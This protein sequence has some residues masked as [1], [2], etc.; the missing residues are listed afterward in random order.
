MCRAWSL[1]V[2]AGLLGSALGCHHCQYTAGVCDCNPPP[3]GLYAAPPPPV[4]HGPP[5]A[6]PAPVAP[7]LA[8]SLRV[9][10]QAQ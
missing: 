3:V 5:A 4:P 8:E 1:L 9:M 6:A 2:G 10:P 7:P